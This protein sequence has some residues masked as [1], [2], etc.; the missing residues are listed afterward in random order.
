MAKELVDAG[1]DGLPTMHNFPLGEAAT[2]LN[3]ARIRLDLI[4]LDYYHRA[5]PGEH[6]TILR[7]TSELAA[8][9]Q[10]TG[11][12]PYGAELGAGFPPFFAP[13]DE[14]DSM[15]TLLSALAYGLRG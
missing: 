14:A 1:F 2:P 4:G 11:A 9:C 13:L 10:G 6:A 5:T 3:A 15:F 8:R 12:P 7:R